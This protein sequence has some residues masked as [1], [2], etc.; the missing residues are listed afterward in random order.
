MRRK[1]YSLVGGFEMGDNGG[2][3]PVVDVAAA[4]YDRKDEEVE[5]EASS[6]SLKE[7]SAAGV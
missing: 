5:T 1:S 4:I 2:R 7:T 3:G 6:A